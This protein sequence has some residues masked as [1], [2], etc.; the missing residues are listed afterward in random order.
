LA[1]SS[2]SFVKPVSIEL[3]RPKDWLIKYNGQQLRA[4][5]DTS[6]ISTVGWSKIFGRG[7]YDVLDETPVY[8]NAQSITVRSAPIHVVHEKS[9][10]LTRFA[11]DFRPV[12]KVYTRSSISA[13][14][15]E[16]AWTEF[17][18]VNCKTGLIEFNS[19]IISSDE[20]LTKVSYTTA[21]SDV[22]VR[23]SGGIP[24]PLNPFLNKDIVKINKPLYVYLKPTEIYKSAST[25]AD[26]ISTSVMRDVIV[27]DYIPGS[28]VNF[29]YNNNIFN[30]YDVSEYDPFALLIGIVYVV[31]TF[32][33]DNFS[34][35]DLRIRGGGISAAFD[36]NKVLNDIDKAISYWDV[37]PALGEA[38][39]K[40]GYVIVKIPKLVKKN[41]TNPDE[42]YTI[43]RNN[44]T[45]GVVFELQ[46]MEGKDWGS[47]VTTT[48]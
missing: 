22:M 43:V 19:S 1:I 37:Y 4:K 25:P 26:Q 48:S 47:S 20:R 6:D 27:E 32:S 42:V 12:L 40:G 15:Q 16:V 28:I 11:A 33:D 36:T 13:P 9:N 3:E 18:N 7:Y 45:A 21:S 39:P 34:F 24:I 10:D 8:N 17:R 2:G 38:Y 23:S 44:I 31:N 46:D 14:W 41:F 29:T 35:Q 30:K 5:Y